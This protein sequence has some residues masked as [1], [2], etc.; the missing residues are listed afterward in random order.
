MK[1]R[2][3]KRKFDILTT[4][5]D[6]ITVLD[7]TYRPDIILQGTGVLQW[8]DLG[9]ATTYD[10][11]VTHFIFY[12]NTPEFVGVQNSD[13]TVWHRVPPRARCVCALVSNAA[14]AGVWWS[15]VVT[16]DSPAYGLTAF[17]D[18]NSW[19][20]SAAGVFDEGLA[21]AV[22][23]AGA[24]AAASTGAGSGALIEGG[25]QGIVV[26]LTGTTIAG[27]C[28]LYSSNSTSY[29]GG[30]CRSFETLQKISAISSAADEYIARYGIGNNLTGGAH[31]RGVYFL[32]DRLGSGVNWQLK[33]I[34]VAGSTLVDS[35]VA[36]LYGTGI[37]GWQKLR[38]EV[39]SAVTR[40]DFW[41]DNVQVSAAGGVTTNLP[42]TNDAI[43]IAHFGITKT[44]DAG[45]NSRN[46][47][48]DY[49]GVGSYPTTLR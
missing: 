29:L 43:K 16:S 24:G 11:G 10:P 12:N 15:E 36:P 44:E 46:L 32:Y 39:D 31:T 35:G 33:N 45:V 37:S 34:N 20:A 18:F 23:G 41:I 17:N 40:S 30:G 28:L 26:V 5:S 1:P 22:A 49:T 7:R 2:G 9:D 4:A 48:V 14:A 19:H 21:F 13:G 38:L 25:K 47:L 42:A 27:W 8:Y 6:T 3:G